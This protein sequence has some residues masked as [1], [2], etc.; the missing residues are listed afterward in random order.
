MRPIARY[1]TAIVIVIL[2]G[3][4]WFIARPHHGK[5][6]QQAT[7]ENNATTEI[8]S[9]ASATG[10][11]KDYTLVVPTSGPRIWAAEVKSGQADSKTG[12]LILTGVTCHMYQHGKEVLKVTADSATA[13]V[14]GKIVHADLS[15]HIYAQDT[16]REQQLHANALRWVST[17]DNMH[18]ENFFWE[19]KG[20]SVRADQ[21]TLTTDLT[22][23]KFHGHVRMETSGLHSRR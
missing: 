5:H 17:E 19:G 12:K 13:R 20:V 8:P 3:I 4:I 9:L 6:H 16:K 11:F 14:V 15:G 7:H 2:A 10:E 23:A 1:V 21:G 22:E 18:V